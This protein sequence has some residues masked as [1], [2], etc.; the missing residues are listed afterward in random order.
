MPMKFTVAE[1][2]KCA[3]RELALRQAVYPKFI[4]S[5]RLK[6]QS[7]DQ[8]IALMQAIVDD[9]TALEQTERLI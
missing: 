6:Q 2:L 4:A 3:K 5:G 1:K 9:Y 8:E 7:A